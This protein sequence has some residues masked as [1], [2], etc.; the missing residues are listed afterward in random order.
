MKKQQNHRKRVSI[1]RKICK[2]FNTKIKIN[3]NDNNKL[4]LVGLQHT[5]PHSS[6]VPVLKARTGNEKVPFELHLDVVRYRIIK[7]FIQVI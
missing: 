2:I 6:A 1:Q 3:K 4:F 7:E 5:Q